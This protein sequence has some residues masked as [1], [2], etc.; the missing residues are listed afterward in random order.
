MKILHTEASTGWGGQEIRILREVTG[1]RDRG[2]EVMIAAP[3]GSGIFINSKK[4]GFKTVPV[5]FKRRNL[6]QIFF[7]LKNLIE[8]ESID[9]V[10]THSSKDSWLAMPAA[11]IAKNNPFIIRTRHLSTPVSRGLMSRFLYNVLPHLIITT[12]EAIRE[13]LININKFDADKIIS[14]PTGV[15][16]DLFTPDGTENSLREELGLPLDTILVGAVSVIRSWKG[17]DYLVRSIPQVLKEFP[18]ARFIIAGDGPHRGNLEKTIKE[19]GVS[20]KIHLLG[21]REDVA[22]IIGSLD[23]V[24]HPSYANEGV[25]QTILQSMAMKRPVIS[26]DLPPLKEVV[27]DE[28]TGILVPIKSPEEISVSIIRLLYDEAL[29]HKLGEAGRELVAS[30][31]SFSGMLDKMEMTYRRKGQYE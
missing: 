25:P 22:N 27:K 26:T 6:L 7:F 13:Q 24:V 16:L 3:P 8:K 15:D 28:I 4:E 19:T 18:R 20:D 9:I 5:E 1:M 30:S 21:H 31:Y 14:I 29:R 2:H 12:G 17:H 23:I 10:N 11:R